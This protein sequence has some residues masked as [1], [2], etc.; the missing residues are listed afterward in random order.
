MRFTRV[1][2]SWVFS[3]PSNTFNTRRASQLQIH[4][5][6]LRIRRVVVNYR[7]VHNVIDHSC[8]TRSLEPKLANEAAEV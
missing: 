8:P 7:I 6:L 2:P 5:T 3:L 1:D 4:Y